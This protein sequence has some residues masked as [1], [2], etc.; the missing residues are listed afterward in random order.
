MSNLDYLREL[1]VKAIKEKQDM[2][3]VLEKKHGELS[4]LQ[5]EFSE[6]GQEYQKKA[7]IVAV[8]ELLIEEE[9]DEPG[10]ID[11]EFEAE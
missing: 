3:A 1:Q 11:A 8:L 5:Q 4:V 2:E 7:A 10:I 6:M 9:K